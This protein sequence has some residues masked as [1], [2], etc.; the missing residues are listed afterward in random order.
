[1]VVFSELSSASADK[2]QPGRL[3]SFLYKVP[4]RQRPGT[5]A[6]SCCLSQRQGHTHLLRSVATY[7][8]LL[9]PD[10]HIP[11]PNSEDDVIEE[12]R[13]L[14][15]VDSPIVDG[16]EAH[17]FLGCGCGQGPVWVHNLP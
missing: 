7:H 4:H 2:L 17:R 1:M 5:A 13:P 14:D 16:V 3:F 6:G 15:G 9:L 11:S 12:R 10:S 8:D